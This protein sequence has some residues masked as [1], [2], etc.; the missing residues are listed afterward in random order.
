MTASENAM[1]LLYTF[2]HTQSLYII[3]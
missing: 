3:I 2:S 1:S